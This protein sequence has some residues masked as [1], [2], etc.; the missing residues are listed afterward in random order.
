MQELILVITDINTHVIYTE[1]SE[2]FYQNKLCVI[3]FKFN[4]YSSPDPT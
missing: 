4:I 2:S 3:T 1:K